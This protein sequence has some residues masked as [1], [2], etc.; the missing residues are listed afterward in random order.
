MVVRSGSI[1]WG[2]GTNGLNITGGQVINYGVMM[3]ENFRIA[4][5]RT[6]EN[7]GSG[8]IYAGY[9][10]GKADD[11]GVLN[12]VY[13]LLLG[14]EDDAF[15][16]YCYWSDSRRYFYTFHDQPYSYKPSTFDFSKLT[17]DDMGQYLS[18][19]TVSF[20]DGAVTGDGSVAYYTP[21]DPYAKDPW[22]MI[23]GY[24]SIRSAWET[25]YYGAK[26]NLRFEYFNNYSRGRFTDVT[27]GKSYE[28]GAYEYVNV[29][30]YRSQVE[31]W[32]EIVPSQE[33]RFWDITAWLDS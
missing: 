8:K 9:S 33:L 20:A 31:G 2:G 10:I 27:T 4:Q 5:Q 26:S 11:I 13:L 12:N 25:A 29:Y 21:D 6:V 15:E 23:Y 14:L 30:E 1:L 16:E 19:Q 32:K 24:S 28:L 18:G 3:G 17:T 22:V 7:K